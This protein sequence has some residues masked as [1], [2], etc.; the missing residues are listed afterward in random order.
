M[1]LETPL[2]LRC[3]HAVVGLGFD[4]PN[5][6][7]R[8]AMSDARLVLLVDDDV[9]L[10]KL[11]EL[12]LSR[13]GYVV[14]VC[15]DGELALETL[16]RVRPDVMLLDMN[17]PGIS[18]IETLKR[19]RKTHPHMPVVVLS[20]DKSVD[21]V[22]SAMQ[23]G[24]YDY[25]VKPHEREHLLE[26]LE[27]ASAQQDRSVRLA[28]LKRET[29]GVGYAGIVGSSE[30]MKRLFSEL[31]RLVSCDI[32]VLIHGES[33]TGKEL[34]ATALHEC[35]GR[36]GAPFVTVNCAA[37]PETLQESELFGHEK[38]AFTGA[39]QRRI[40]KFEAADGGTIFLDE[41]AELTPP[42][43]ARLLRV[44]QERK[45]TRLGSNEE[46]KS[47]FRLV[48]AS[49]RDLA[50]RVREGAFREDLFYRLAVYE[51]EVP[52]LRER[53]HDV[54]ELAQQFLEDA[55]ERFGI[56]EPELSPPVAERLMS[57]PWPGNVRELQNAMR[58][59]VVGA[60]GERVLPQHLP[61]TLRGDVAE[62]AGALG[63]AI[64]PEDAAFASAPPMRPSAV[65]ASTPAAA[66][67]SKPLDDASVVVSAS[68]GEFPTLDDA[69]L[70][71]IRAALKHCKGN[72]SEACRSLGTSRT[73]LYRKLER[74][75]LRDDPES[76]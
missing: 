58:R 63:I 39:S 64:G 2:G 72:L 33:G 54:I 1:Q 24:A 35:S 61:P 50:Q 14:E 68:N 21:R 47:D 5:P 41:I 10:T 17:L 75:G 12:W 32:S 48:C 13:K 36:A 11:V 46:R 19:V 15:H 69:E 37:I 65:V 66:A 3:E 20:S 45:F 49:H 8:E 31:D 4:P 6:E 18:G 62:R 28:R 43:Q 57:Y 59:A 52:A 34:V 40:G 16:S 38:G 7:T 73:T 42:T 30:P 56:P 71:L 53:G 44:L 60:Q 76:A 26:T 25:L 27:H 23:L 29:Q 70:C 74:F 55:A 51:L 9:T 67:L 22:V